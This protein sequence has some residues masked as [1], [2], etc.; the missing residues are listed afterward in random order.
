MPRTGS[1]IRALTGARSPRS[2]A[3]L[4]LTRGSSTS[5]GPAGVLAHKPNDLFGAPPRERD[6]APGVAVVV[7]DDRTPAPLRVDARAARTARAQPHA[8]AD[9]LRP[10]RA[11]VQLGT[12][13]DD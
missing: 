8:G 9:E 5:P 1:T 4:A 10:C 7:D 11:N 3:R 2:P 12:P 6:P 13:L